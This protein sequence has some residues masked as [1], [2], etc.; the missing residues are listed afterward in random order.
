MR[1]N[2]RWAALRLA[3]A[4]P[5]TQTRLRA[6][7]RLPTKCTT[8]GAMQSLV[9]ASAAPSRRLAASPPLPPPLLPPANDPPSPPQ[10]F[11]GGAASD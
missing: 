7:A 8:H 6:A 1:Q 4:A 10:S 11:A 9:Q 5:F 2:Y 3:C